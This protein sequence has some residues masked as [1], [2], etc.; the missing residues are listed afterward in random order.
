FYEKIPITRSMGIRV[1]SSEPAQFV[2]EAP[3]LL[4]HNHLGTAFG[5]SLSAIAT[6]A[7]YGMIWLALQDRDSHVVIRESAITYRR[8]VR[9]NIRAICRLPLPAI[10]EAFRGNFAKKGKARI[11]LSVVIEE[12]GEVAVRFKGTFVALK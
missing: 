5:G 6:L 4:N 12:E 11:N 8:P 3:L 9:G 1:I 2:I 10:V 7:G